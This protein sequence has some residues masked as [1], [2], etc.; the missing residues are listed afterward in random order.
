[1]DVD[2]RHPDASDAGRE[3]LRRVLRRPA[4]AAVVLLAI[5]LG[6]SLLNDEAGFL[7]TD[8][9]GKAATLRVMEARGDWDPDVGYWAEAWDPEA[10]VHGLYYT[11]VFGGRYVNV[12]TLP[13]VLAA[14][15]LWGLGG[16][17]ATL[18]LP[19]AGSVAAAFAARALAQRVG[20]GD[21]WSAYWIVGLASP[22]VV[23]ALDLWEHS[24]G[25]ALMAWGAVA[26]VDAVELRP[27]WW[28]GL[29]AGAAFGAAA[30]MRTEAFAYGL[31]MTAVACVVLALGQRRAIGAAVVV[32]AGALAGFVT[33]FAANL[34]LEVLVLGEP[35]RS[36]RAAGA[37][38]AGLG[39]HGLRAREG[40]VT[41]VSPFP[42]MD[43]QAW[44]VG[45][46]LLGALCYAAVQAA[47]P[48]R[49]RLAAAA[50]VVAGVVYLWR[51]SDGLGFV[52]GLVAATPF[53][54][55]GLALG[56]RDARSRLVL[57][58]AL[59]PLPVV[60][61]FQFTGGA[62]PQWA[63][64]Y[65]LT[66]GL[67]LATVG[68]AGAHRMARWAQVGFVVASVAV[69]AFGVAWLS[70][71]SHEIA[72]AA[73]RFE[74]RP[75]PVLISP[76]GFIPREFGASYPDRRWLASGSPE[77]LRFAVDVVAA[78]GEDAFALFD[79]D[80]AAD[81]PTFPGWRV[82]SSELVPFLS[83]V[84]MRVTSYARDG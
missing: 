2:R 62:A 60:F 74:S 79:L 14:K 70:V 30:A 73:R 20:G 53:A 64:R 35:M 69:T 38:G 7:G 3:V 81:P 56:W 80:T 50:A 8:T 5:Y 57:A 40:L 34:A 84:E 39:E 67:L 82:V 15:P 10:R 9:G 4:W 78:A 13:M 29:A 21:G 43:A 83:G 54:A 18:L 24:A 41:T 66:S 31:A 46:C 36:G 28:R 32:G 47:R 65:V 71:R 23:Y 44:L 51:F 37:A 16:Y 33:L 76:N 42:T 58:L 72:A 22:L 17:R 12:S 1:M 61:A 49:E 59:V 27:T 52:P 45:A 75:E 19:M 26:L 11:Y 63:G 6:L 25:V 68:I 55:V 48:G 77:D